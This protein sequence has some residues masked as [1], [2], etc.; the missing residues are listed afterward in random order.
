MQGSEDSIKSFLEEL[1][2][3]PSA[4]DVLKVEKENIKTKVCLLQSD[5]PLGT[6]PD[7]V[8]MEGE[9]TFTSPYFLQKM[10]PRFETD[11][12]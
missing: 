1:N 2:K 11:C 10:R 7:F 6:N 4:A 5:I 3:G 8:K 12:E 9:C